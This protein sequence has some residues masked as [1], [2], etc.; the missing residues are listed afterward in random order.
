MPPSH[1]DAII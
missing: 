1:D